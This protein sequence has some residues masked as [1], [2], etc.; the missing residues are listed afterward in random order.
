MTLHYPEEPVDEEF[1]RPP[2]T[3][4]DD[5]GRKIEVERADDNVEG[6]VGMYSEFDA[7]DRAQGI[8]PSGESNIREWLDVV[9]EQ[10]SLN[11]IGWH[12]DEPVGH[13]ML[14]A[15]KDGSYELA[16]FVAEEY[17]G[18]GIGTEV[19]RTSLGAAQEH[20]I[21]RVWLSVERW[22]QPAIKLYDKLGFERM[23]DTGF[24]LEMTIRLGPGSEEE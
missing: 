7:G 5:E 2:R 21:D 8:P 14:V 18:A 11:V 24:E 19:M 16:I 3:F 9:L 1:P 6:L 22:N 15:D 12:E 13:A 10:E 17:R 20:G 23:T 4:R